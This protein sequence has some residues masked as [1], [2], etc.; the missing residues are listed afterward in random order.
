VEDIGQTQNLINTRVITALENSRKLFSFMYGVN[1][2]EVGKISSLQELSVLYD[3]Q[4]QPLP[5]NF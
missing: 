4:G 2:G 5:V 3:T 1:K